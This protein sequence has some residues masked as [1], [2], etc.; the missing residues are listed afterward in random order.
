MHDILPEDQPYFQRVAEVTANLVEFYG[1]KR[2]DPVVL[3]NVEVFTRGIG[4]VTDI[5]EKEMYVLKTRGGD[6]LAM[7][8]EFTAGIARSYIEHG[9]CA[10][11][12]PVKLYAMGQIFRA[13][14]PQAGRYRQFN[15]WDLEIFGEDSPA[16][17]AQVIQVCWNVLRE[18]GLKDT[19]VE[20][21]SIGDSQCR[22]YYKKLLMNYLRSRQNNMCA[23]CR[24]RLKKN[25]LRVLDCKEERCRKI[26]SNSPKIIDHLCEP[27]NNHFKEVLEFLDELELP[28]R[29][30]HCL[31]R[32]LDYYTRTV[33]EVFSE[34]APGKKIKG[35][36]KDELENNDCPI[37]AP[38][39][40]ALAGGGRLD[41]LIKML[42]GK[43]TPAC[44]VAGG[45]ERLVNL[46][47][48]QGV[49]PAKPLL[50]QVFLAQIGILAKRKSLRLFEE[51][52]K[53]RI[54]VAESLGRDSL[55]AQLGRAQKAEV[56]F[57][58]ILG[59]QEALDGTVIIRDMGVGR[60]ETVK[61][62]RAVEEM[63][64]R[65]RK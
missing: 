10:L 15:Q 33:F 6:V 51:F 65:L 47:K 32:G 45:I 13:E 30:N 21:N 40:I 23:D 27:C 48:A 4:E 59:Q 42:G 46:M 61:L 53:S 41:N 28:Y 43:D 7:R 52:R 60:Q 64:K 34:N 12:Q 55:K 16:I 44:G 11:P 19:I 17:D 56:R 63:K 26:V 39:Q 36:E 22:P 49:R 5:V 18:L 38:G 3:E 54:R 37:E 50:P 25:P 20:V 31:V 35:K 58:L 62:E 1:F 2:I 24:S 57:A 29:L 9:M 8:P 14:R